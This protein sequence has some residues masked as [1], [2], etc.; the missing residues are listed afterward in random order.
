MAAKV[1]IFFPILQSA[2]LTIFRQRSRNVD[3]VNYGVGT[4]YLLLGKFRKKIFITYQIKI[5]DIIK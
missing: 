4:T 1:K 2:A 3:G 5:N